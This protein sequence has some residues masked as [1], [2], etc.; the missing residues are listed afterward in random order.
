M[1]ASVTVDPGTTS[2]TFQIATVDSPAATTVTITARYSGV[3]Q[4]ATLTVARLALQ[5]LALTENSVPGGLSVLGI[6]TLTVAAPPGGV[7]VSLS[8]SN[9]ADATVPASV[10]VAE[11]S[12]VQTFEIDTVNSPPTTAATITATYAGV[13]RTATLT[14]TAYPIV[15]ALS[16]SPTNPSGGTS[17]QCTGSLANPAP[18]GGWQLSFTSSDPSATVPGGVAVPASSQTFQFTITTVPVSV[19]TIVTIQINDAQSGYLLFT[20]LLDVTM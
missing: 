13:S 17:V 1:P 19:E 11:G 6:I 7:S 14:V 16:C 4:T 12:T 8:S 5:T 20:D 18:S 10:T 2:Q 15:T 3:V 9:S